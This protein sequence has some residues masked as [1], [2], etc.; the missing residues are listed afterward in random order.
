MRK[1]TFFGGGVV[2]SAAMAYADG[3]FSLEDGSGGPVMVVMLIIVLVCVVAGAFF[4]VKSL[5]GI[6]KAGVVEKLGGAGEK[7]F[8]EVLVSKEEVLFKKNPKK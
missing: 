6:K 1:I 7:P 3:A 2:F 4:A 5:S 8:A